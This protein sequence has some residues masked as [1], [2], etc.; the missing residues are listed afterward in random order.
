MAR[1]AVNQQQQVFPAAMLGREKRHPT[2]SLC[3][4]KQA[5]NKWFGSRKQLLTDSSPRLFSLTDTICYPMVEFP[6]FV[7][8]I[9]ALF[10]LIDSFV[11]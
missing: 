6:N 2:L 3:V 8:A 4:R 5:N 11:R 1:S 10:F 7:C 9:M